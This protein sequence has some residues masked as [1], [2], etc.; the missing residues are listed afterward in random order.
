[1]SVVPAAPTLDLLPAWHD[2]ALL[3]AHPTPAELLA[4]LGEAPA[5]PGPAA[6]A[7]HAPTRAAAAAADAEGVRGVG[8][9][10]GRGECR[11]ETLRVTVQAPAT[12]VVAAGPPANGPLSAAVG[13]FRVTV[14]Q[15]AR[16]ARGGVAKQAHVARDFEGPLRAA[17]AAATAA[18]RKAPSLT[19]AA[20]MCC[21]LAAVSGAAAWTHSLAA[22]SASP[23]TVEDA[24]LSLTLE[25][26]RSPDVDVV[27]FRVDVDTVAAASFH[28]LAADQAADADASVS[29]SPP[30]RLHLRRASLYVHVVPAPAVELLGCLRLRVG[31]KHVAAVQVLTRGTAAL[32][33]HT[34]ALITHSVIVAFFAL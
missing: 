31:G 4:E 23:A 7:A 8:L 34:H 26:V 33:V 19:V 5:A 28:A 9:R 16:V 24:S 20:P 13:D 17:A 2:R 21:S 14:H 32:Y 15:Y 18:P 30:R 12:A 3:P 22:P 25:F 1:V 10:L 27:A 29:P 11:L 6:L